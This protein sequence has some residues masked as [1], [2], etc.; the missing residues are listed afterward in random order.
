LSLMLCEYLFFLPLSLFLLVLTPLF[1]EHLF[2]IN[3]FLEVCVLIVFCGDVVAAA[4]LLI[5]VKEVEVLG[6]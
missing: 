1:L 4:E 6:G 3:R 5:A 2:L